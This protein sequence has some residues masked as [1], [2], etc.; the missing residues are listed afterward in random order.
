M[1]A[2]SGESK[3]TSIKAHKVAKFI[4]FSIIIAL[5]AFLIDKISSFSR[6]KTIS[7]AKEGSTWEYYYYW[8]ALAI[9]TYKHVR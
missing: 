3:E 5:P 4:F 1:L 7:C 9:C 2:E 8:A 6:N